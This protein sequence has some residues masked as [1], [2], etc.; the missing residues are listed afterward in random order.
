MFGSANL[1][2]DCLFSSFKHDVYMYF[3][4]P[5]GSAVALT[6]S[7]F[8]HPVEY[9]DAQSDDVDQTTTVCNVFCTAVHHVA[10][11]AAAV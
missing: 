3:H 1:T 9:M 2:Q 4:V 11:A 5:L 7:S 6:V 10:F 8:R